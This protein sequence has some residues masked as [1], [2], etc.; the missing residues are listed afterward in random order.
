MKG[1]CP[2]ERGKPKAGKTSTNQDNIEPREALALQRFK[3]LMK[4]NAGNLRFSG[5]S[6]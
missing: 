4:D 5:L 2:S 1:K 3:D 6:D